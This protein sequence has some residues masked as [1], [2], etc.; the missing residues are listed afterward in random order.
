M[1]DTTYEDEGSGDLDYD[2]VY[3]A[4][5]QNNVYGFDSTIYDFQI[6]LPESG[7]EGTQ[8]N[9]VYYFYVELV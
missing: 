6:L 9:T 1:T 7:L 2:L 4:L 5:I 8:A 3:A